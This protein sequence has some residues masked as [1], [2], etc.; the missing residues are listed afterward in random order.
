MKNWPTALRYCRDKYTEL[1]A[2]R[3]QDESDKLHRLL[4]KAKAK[5][6]WI[7]LLD[8]MRVWKWSLDGSVFHNHNKYESWKPGQPSW[9]TE[10]SSCVTVMDDGDWQDA[11]CDS[12]FPSVCYNGKTILFFLQ[13]SKKTHF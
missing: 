2:V 13:A 6:A 4:Q 1:A 3:S 11:K 5:D 8:D 7:G 9:T 10:S 12:I